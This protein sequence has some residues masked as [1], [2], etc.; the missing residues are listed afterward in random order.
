MQA[1][2]QKYTITVADMELNIV[3]DAAADE[4]DS[5]VA[6][7]DRRM[8]DI[9]KK[10]PRCSKSEAA[11]LSALSY[12]SERIAMQEAFKK[13]E[14]DAFRYASENE[15]LK[16]TIEHMQEEL[17]NLR[18]DAQVMRT[19]LDRTAAEKEKPKSVPKSA[20]KRIVREATQL[21]AFDN[22]PEEEPVQLTAPVPPAV[23]KQAEPAAPAKSAEETP[24]KKAP[25]KGKKD[26]KTKSHIGSM[27]DLLTFSDV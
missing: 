3:S 26:A 25:K 11:I 13:V 23:V 12:C 1:M 5:I 21:S 7:L 18:R 15:R 10:S 8:K 20:P 24:E 6:M 19:V 9:S 22:L 17:D 4:V 16:K 27:F 14:K 2:K